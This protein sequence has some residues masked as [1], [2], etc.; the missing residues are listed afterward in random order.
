MSTAAIS[1]VFG[2]LGLSDQAPSFRDWTGEQVTVNLHPVR[3]HPIG[4]W[5]YAMAKAMSGPQASTVFRSTASKMDCY[6]RL[7]AT[8]EAP[9]LPQDFHYTIFNQSILGASLGLEAAL[10]SLFDQ[11]T[12]WR[13]IRQVGRFAT[14]PGLYWTRD[15]D[16]P[17]FQIDDQSRRGR[18]AM[19]DLEEGAQR[20]QRL[21]HP[22]PS[23]QVRM[24]TAIRLVSEDEPESIDGSLE[25]N[26]ELAFGAFLHTR[27]IGLDQARMEWMWT[28]PGT[29]SETITWTAAIREGIHPI[30]AWV[31][32][33]RGTVESPLQSVRMNVEWHPSRFHPWILRTGFA[34][35]EDN[36]FVPRAELVLL[37]R[38]RWRIPH[39]PQHSLP[40]LHPLSRAPEWPLIANFGPNEIT[41]IG[42]TSSE[43]KAFQ[44]ALKRK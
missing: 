37:A 23:P 24:G 42:A 3:P 9:P 41:T 31:F 26:G 14:G 38:T 44:R 25:F 35:K 36:D 34:L 29:R 28:H 1:L 32:S 18:M 5:Q 40:G 8:G 17:Q 39:S 11:S 10:R 15:H 7:S 22:L 16:G 27:H 21:S 6:W 4:Q 12:E 33:A 2:W 20:P 13:T 30:M 43:D 19:L